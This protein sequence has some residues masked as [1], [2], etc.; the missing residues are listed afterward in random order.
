MACV[1]HSSCANPTHWVLSLSLSLDLVR[2]RARA[3]ALSL[4]LKHTKETFSPASQL[5]SA[6]A[7]VGLRGPGG[8]RLAHR[9]ARAR[10]RH[11]ENRPVSAARALP[12]LE[13]H[14]TKRTA[15]PRISRARRAPR[16]RVPPP[17]ETAERA[18]VVDRGSVA[19]RDGCGRG[20]AQ[21]PAGAM[22]PSLVF[23]AASV[24]NATLRTILTEW[25]WRPLCVCTPRVRT[26]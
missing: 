6:G 14:T 19:A 11:Q 17:Q 22:R 9:L 24:E 25:V 7:A 2:E 16:S 21:G 5:P 13:N 18:A 26:I 1:E 4:P 10:R 23:H 8:D 15:F 20:G 3:R 12:A